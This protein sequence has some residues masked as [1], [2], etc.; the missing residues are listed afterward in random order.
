DFALPPPLTGT[1][2]LSGGD[3][4]TD[5]FAGLRYSTSFAERW[6][7]MARGDLGAGDSDLAWNASVYFGYAVGKEPQNLILFGYRHLQFEL[8]E[9]SAGGQRAETDLTFSGP[10]LGFAFR[11]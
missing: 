3:T 4:L 5:G 6:E 8:K 11:F 1:Q 9:S 2:R 7:F 10:A